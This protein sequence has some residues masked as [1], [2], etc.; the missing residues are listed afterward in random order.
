MIASF[1]L[2]FTI[3]HLPLISHFS[4]LNGQL[5]NDKSLKI[6]N[7]KLKTAAGGSL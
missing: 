2:P 5:L 3:Y 7:C 1:H 6:V 4:F